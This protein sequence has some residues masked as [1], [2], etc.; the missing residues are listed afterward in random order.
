MKTVVFT[1]LQ[2]PELPLGVPISFLVL[3]L[4]LMIN[5]ILIPGFVLFGDHMGLVI[6]FALAAIIIAYVCGFIMTKIDPEW[7][8]CVICRLRTLPRT[9]W[10]AR[11]GIHYHG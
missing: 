2:K 1:E 3:I 7:M 11:N 4:P 8:N 5:L 6:M 9:N 10:P